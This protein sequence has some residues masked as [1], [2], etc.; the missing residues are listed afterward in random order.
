M[1]R[2]KINA[3]IQVIGI[4]LLILAST[5]LAGCMSIHTA[6]R[7]PNLAEIKKQLA[8]G[9]NPNSKTFWYRDTPLIVAAAYGHTEVVKLLLDKGAH[10]NMGNEGGETALHYAARHGHTKVMQILLEHGADPKL[11]GTG[12]GT[13]LQWAVRGGQTQ[14]VKML[15]D[16]GVNINQRGTDGETALATA[17]SEY[18]DMV[19]FLISLGADV[20]ARAENGC[21]PLHKAYW[22]ENKEVARLLLQRG[23]DPTLQCNDGF[24]VPQSFLDQL[25]K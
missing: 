4:A 19:S 6:A 2:K 5:L 24:K 12:C 7:G 21:T 11:K 1:N 16:Y 18:P 17:V 13:P 20:N 25:G 9:A 14:S 8:W 15:L 23:A 10:V 22:A 3:S